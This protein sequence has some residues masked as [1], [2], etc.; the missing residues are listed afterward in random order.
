MK[1]KPSYYTANAGYKRTT[2]A[3]NRVKAAFW[4]KI[5]DEKFDTSQ[6]PLPILNWIVNSFS[7]GKFSKQLIL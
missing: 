6:K 4:I 3:T 1:V 5:N 7:N 2:F